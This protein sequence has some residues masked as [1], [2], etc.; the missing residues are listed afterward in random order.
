MEDPT[1]VMVPLAGHNVHLRPLHWET[2]CFITSIDLDW[3][4]GRFALEQS[5]SIILD[6]LNLKYEE[7][8]YEGLS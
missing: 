5:L 2:I 3:G 1:H 4:I 8:K 6:F 7:Y